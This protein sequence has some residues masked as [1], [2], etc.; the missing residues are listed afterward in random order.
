MKT[1]DDNVQH[2]ASKMKKKRLLPLLDKLNQAKATIATKRDDSGATFDHRL[3][4]DLQLGPNKGCCICGVVVSVL[5]PPE[6]V[7]L[8]LVL[9]DAAG[10]SFAMSVF[11]LSSAASKST[12]TAKHGGGGVEKV[13]T[14]TRVKDVLTV[15]DPMLRELR[16][17]KQSGTADGSQHGE[18]LILSIREDR[19]GRLLRNGQPMPLESLARAQMSN[20]QPT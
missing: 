20:L 5:S 14:S 9:V 17:D 12:G 3:F 13:D 4:S 10:V 6:G 19:P 16:L 18:Y 8:V 1:V 15:F 2:A 7:P 11:N